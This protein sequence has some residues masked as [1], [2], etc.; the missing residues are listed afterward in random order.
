VNGGGALFVGFEG[1]ELRRGERRLLARLAPAGVVLLPRN[2]VH[3]EQ[4]A[5]LVAELRRLCPGAILALDAEG[6]RVDRLRGVVGPSPAAAVLARCRSQMALRAGRWVG[7]ALRAFDFDLDLAP[8]VDLDRGAQANALDGRCFGPNPRAVRARAGAFLSGLHRAG[9][10][11]CLKHFPGLGG[12]DADTHEGPAWIPLPRRELTRD[13]APFV[14]LA[15]AADAVLLGHALYPRLVAD[16]LPATLSPAIGRELLRGRLKFRGAALSDDLEMAA[17][18]AYGDL[19]E[20]GERSLLAGCDGLL[21]CRRLEE[22][23]SVAKRLARP[24]LARRL[25]QAETRL[26]ALRRALAR[27][28]RQAGAPRSKAEIRRRLA[29]L[30]AT[31]AP[32]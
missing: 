10:G 16:L 30:A 21:L 5:A 18:A 13:L 2:I 1:P 22:A 14:A 9:M 23:P 17:L 31:C 25:R 28:R 15:P 6:G 7:E 12:A 24:R 11:G 32:R 8:V 27:H 19:P 4:L 26:A 29:T 3:A 20:L